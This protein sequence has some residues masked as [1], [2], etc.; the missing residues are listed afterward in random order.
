M[1]QIYVTH[2]EPMCV[3]SDALLVRIWHVIQQALSFM[4]TRHLFQVYTGISGPFYQF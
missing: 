4:F 3:E 2:V 1:S